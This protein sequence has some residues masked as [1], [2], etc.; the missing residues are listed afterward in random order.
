MQRV[1]SVSSFPGAGRCPALPAGNPLPAARPVSG[2][3]SDWIRGD[4]FRDIARTHSIQ[5]GVR[6]PL[7]A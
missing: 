1:R 7:R 5:H 3:A 4:A 2:Q 6:A